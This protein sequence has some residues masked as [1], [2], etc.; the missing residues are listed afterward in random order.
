MNHEERYR[1]LKKIKQ[2]VEQDPSLYKDIN[3]ACSHGILSAIKE[4]TQRAS[5]METIAIAAISLSNERYKK[6]SAEWI[7]N[8]IISKAERWKHRGFF[9][10]ES[11][12]DTIKGKDEND[13]QN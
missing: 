7:K 12:I 13:S 2:E 6:S 1:F 8:L 5:D 11:S 9:D 10:W 3:E 4:E